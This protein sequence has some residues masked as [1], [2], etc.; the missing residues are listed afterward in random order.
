[1]RRAFLLFAKRRPLCASFREGPDT[2]AVARGERQIEQ[3]YFLA[4]DFSSTPVTVRFRGCEARVTLLSGAG[5]LVVG[6]QGQLVVRVAGRRQELRSL[7]V[8]PASRGNEVDY[9]IRF[10]ATA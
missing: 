6:Q 2:V 10:T 3:R 5:Y 7:Q 4:G 8:A 9:G 1:M